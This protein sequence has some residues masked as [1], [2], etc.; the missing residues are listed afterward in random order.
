MMG[1]ADWDLTPTPDR[2]IPCYTCL[3]IISPRDRRR[4]IV[5]AQEVCARCC[6]M[7]ELRLDPV[8]LP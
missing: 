3:R 1:F 7:L 5:E 4:R 2:E 6:H 8:R